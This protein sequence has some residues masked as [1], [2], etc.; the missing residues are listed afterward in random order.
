MRA[1]HA[2]V[3]ST[4]AVIDRRLRDA[5]RRGRNFRLYLDRFL[6]L[7]LGQKWRIGNASRKLRA[8]G[9]RIRVEKNVI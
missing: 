9:Q 6:P 4:G 7:C 3:T 1:Q 5:T 8:D 2:V